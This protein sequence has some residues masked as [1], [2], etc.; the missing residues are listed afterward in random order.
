MFSRFWVSLFVGLVMSLLLVAT[1]QA[2]SSLGL[3]YDLARQLD[4]NQD[5][6]QIN[7]SL[8]AS[9]ARRSAIV[10]GLAEGDK[11]KMV[12]AGFKRYNEKYLSGSFYQL[13]FGYWFG[14]RD[15]GASSEFG[16]D[17]RLGYE[18]PVTRNLVISGA[19]STLYGMS[20]P[21]TGESDA[22]IFRPHLGVMFHF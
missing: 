16:L 9:V 22:L 5:D 21:V 6:G 17:F 2:A 11:Y 4:K 8:Q 20:N 15:K 19:V 13:G 12:E 3:G 14:D 7:F 1:A 18:L 10:F